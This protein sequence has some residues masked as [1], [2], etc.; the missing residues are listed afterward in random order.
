MVLQLNCLTDC[1][2]SCCR[3]AKSVRAGLKERG[4]RM[5]RSE[6]HFS[7]ALLSVLNLRVPFVQRIESGV[8]G[9]GIPDR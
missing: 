6:A 3:A 7:R 4:Y 8:T 1:D 5:Y 2:G 9:S